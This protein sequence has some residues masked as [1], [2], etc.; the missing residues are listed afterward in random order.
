MLPY[1][2]AEGY[3]R[4]SCAFYDYRQTPDHPTVQMKCLVYA[5]WMAHYTTDASM[6][7]HTTRDY[8]GRNQPDGT[9]KQKGIHAKIDAFPEKNK[10]TPEEICRGLEA[11]RIENVWEQ[12][13][14]MVNDS[15]QHIARCYELDAAG[16]FDNP[17]EESRAFILE[18]CRAG[19]QFTMDVWYAAWLR[20]AKMPPHY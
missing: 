8:D 13:L 17:T 6:P 1:S 14:K 16:A 11:K 7:L 19:A 10:L 20:S 18:R 15:H 5:G 2:V 3:D 12:T 4:L 9:V